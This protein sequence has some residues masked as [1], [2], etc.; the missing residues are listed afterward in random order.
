MKHSFFFLFTLF[1]G[2]QLSFGQIVSWHSYK[3]KNLSDNSE[4]NVSNNMTWDLSNGATINIKATGQAGDDITFTLSNG[5][6]RSTEYSDPYAYPSSGWS[7]QIGSV[8]FTVR[9]FVDGN[10]DGTDYFTINF[11]DSSASSGGGG[12]WTQTGSDI[13]YSGGNVGIGTNSPIYA[14][15]IFGTTEVFRLGDS[16]NFLLV[17]N[18]LAGANEIRSYGL[19]LEI[20]TRNSQD[21]SF[22]SNNGTNNLLTIKGDG[23]GV[24]IG[25]TNPGTWKLAVKG[26][27]RAEEIKVETGWADY[28]FKEGYDLPT[29]LEVERHI[30][31]KGH[32]INIPSEEEVAENG[33]HLGEMNKLL[34]EKI[35]EMTLYIL[36]L[37]KRI[38]SLETN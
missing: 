33:V 24:G 16:T 4:T 34:L 3:I 19:G 29:L 20:E 30:R 17:R 21:I 12:Y 18:N 37:E 28:V 27:I 23:S 1:I 31:E 32:L 11:I 25:T 2:F 26:K 5:H 9:H 8:D 13:H 6:T 35:E 38:A 10:D 22:N 36:Q 15:D 7:P 14:L